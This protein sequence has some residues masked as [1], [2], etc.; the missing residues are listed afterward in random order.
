MKL[1]L[2]I[3]AAIL[4]SAPTAA[5]GAHGQSR[6]NVNAAGRAPKPGART[7]ATTVLTKAGKIVATP[8]G[9]VYV[10]TRQTKGL[11]PRPGQRVV[12]NY[13][14]LLTSGLKFDSSLD[15]GQPFVFELGRGRVIKGWD[16]GIGRLR[17]GEQATL[18]IPPE[19]GYGASRPGHPIPPNATLIFNVELVG[20][21]EE[22]A[23]QK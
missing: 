4:S 17:V 9:L 13:T 8:S 1:T 18:I 5:F 12:V 7:R 22:P 20:I 16:E 6:K 21:E 2:I 15:R 3:I 11:L 19:L 10:V 23:A 14:G